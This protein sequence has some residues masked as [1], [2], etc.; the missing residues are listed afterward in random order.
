MTA[1]APTPPERSRPHV[2]VVGSAQATDKELA[3]A[4]EIGG[5]LAASSAVLVCGGLGGVME[6]ACRGAAR[7]GG[8]TI[9]ILPG[10]RRQDANPWVGVAVPTGMG[11][12]RNGLV[13]RTADVLLAIGGEY[14]TLSEIALALKIGRPVVGLRS[15]SVVRP[16]A[17]PDTGVVPARDPADAVARALALSPV[18]TGAPPPDGATP[19]APLRGAGGR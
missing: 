2:A 4:D 9:G 16:D 14:G 17:T 12:L 15:F 6:A 1:D 11:E 10:D 19:P 3:A 18:A 7:A 13:V 5:L 8:L